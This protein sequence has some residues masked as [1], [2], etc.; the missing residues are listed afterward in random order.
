MEITN[1]TKSIIDALDSV[2]AAI[3]QVSNDSTAS[4][5]SVKSELKNLGEEQLKMARELLAI[6]QSMEDKAE[7]SATVTDN[8]VG[9][10]FVATK[11]FDGVK[12]DIRNARSVREIISTK[13]A[14]T[15]IVGVGDTIS[16]NTLA[17]PY[18]AGFVGTPE[19]PLLIEGLIPHVP[20][21]TSTIEY[22]RE[23]VFEN[24]AA[25][26]AEG[27]RKPESTF[28]FELA[29][30]SVETVAH[31]T[32]ITEQLAADA[33]ALA[34]YINAKMVYGLQLKIDR[35]LVNGT[36]TGGQLSGLLNTGNYTDYKSAITVPSGADLIDFA[37]LIKTA[38]ETAMFAPRYLVLNPS[39][40]AAL[41]LLKDK[42]G[43]YILGGPATLAQK[44]IW[45][46]EVITTA[47]MPNGKYLMA[48]FAR[49][50]TIY[51]REEV[52]VA[53]DRESD[54]FIKNLFTIRVERR[55]GLVVD[56]P[57]AIGGGDWSIGS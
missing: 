20:V 52:A 34:A 41:A 16:R 44:T 50:A 56:T 10:K 12:G 1:E 5:N 13:S 4:I 28:E 33:P 32:K 6:Q 25:V 39:D 21:S 40:W 2:N 29:K 22:V 27:A 8:S 35:Q 30:G 26:V 47:S 55:L 15:S 37:L 48:D 3:E 31:W 24:N 9:S 57:A 49:G 42:Q 54:D 7:K 38:L 19:Q 18:Q 14:T 11:S 23:K 36:G 43:R 51:D 17:V 53:M 46:T 45:G